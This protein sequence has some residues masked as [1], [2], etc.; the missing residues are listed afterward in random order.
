M[1][2]VTPIDVD[3]LV[4]V[5]HLDPAAHRHHDVLA[6]VLDMYATL[7]DDA[8]DRWLLAH[9]VAAQLLNCR[10]KEGRAIRRAVRAATV[11]VSAG[12][13]PLAL[14]SG[15]AVMETRGRSFEWVG[16]RKLRKGEGKGMTRRSGQYYRRSTLYVAVSVDVVLVL[17]GLRSLLPA[18]LPP[19]P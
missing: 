14:V 8:G 16:K 1:T 3:A 13:V 18:V 4:P 5:A 15:R 19:T 9:C 17:A 6:A 7:Q 11:G 12:V 10:C 2:P